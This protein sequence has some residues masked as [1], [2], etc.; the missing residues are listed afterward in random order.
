MATGLRTVP[1]FFRVVPALVLCIVAL[2]EVAVRSQQV[3]TGSISGRIVDAQGNGMPA[4]PVSLRAPRALTFA[5]TD[6]D[7]RFLFDALYP[8]E[9]ALTIAPLTGFRGIARLVRV[10]S[11]QKLELKERLELGAVCECIKT[12]ATGSLPVRRPAPLGTIEGTVT[13]PSGTPVPFA[14][15]KITTYV[16]DTPGAVGYNHGGDG[17]ADIDGRY[18]L[19][20]EPGFYDLTATSFGLGSGTS[21]RIRALSDKRVTA[22]IRLIPETGLV[23]SSNVE[24]VLQ[25]LEGCRCGNRLGFDWMGPDGHLDVP[26]WRKPKTGEGRPAVTAALSDSRAEADRRLCLPGRATPRAL[27]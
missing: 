27:R 25:D 11:G 9:Y 21:K 4:W 24:Q 10:A 20:A 12:D 22:D 13:D 17:Y 19:A 2:V 7:G 6:S 18:R 8:G 5:R 23:G 16:L 1:L 14:S 26:W 15:L 3:Q